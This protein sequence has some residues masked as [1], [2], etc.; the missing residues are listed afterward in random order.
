MCS[1]S[2]LSDFTLRND[3]SKFYPTESRPRISQFYSQGDSRPE[4][5]AKSLVPTRKATHAAFQPSEIS[6]V[7]SIASSTS[8]AARSWKY[9][10]LYA[11]GSSVVTQPNATC[12]AFRAM[13]ATK[14]TAMRPQ[15][16]HSGKCG[17]AYVLRP[18]AQV[19]GLVLVGLR[20]GTGM[21]CGQE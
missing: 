1:A 16:V 21:S 11:Q 10:V 20:L 14:I 8:C 2:H 7:A 6:V 15:T 13:G 5:Q 12:M 18:L 3:N 19:C 9:D 17:V 4:R